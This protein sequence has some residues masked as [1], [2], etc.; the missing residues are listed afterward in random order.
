[1]TILVQ[2]Q[3]PDN[4]KLFK[5]WAPKFHWD[6]V[7]FKK[8]LRTKN[9]LGIFGLLWLVIKF[10]HWPLGE[11]RR[12]FLNLTHHFSLMRRNPGLKSEHG[13]VKSPERSVRRSWF[14]FGSVPDLL[15]KLGLVCFPS[16]G[17]RICF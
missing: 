6:K 4:K 7:S 11:G 10:H 15:R 13:E 8:F 2:T 9:K 5:A 1:M 16:L 12:E 3:K 17:P 14:L